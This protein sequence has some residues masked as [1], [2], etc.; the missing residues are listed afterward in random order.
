MDLTERI[1]A[2]ERLRASEAQLRELAETLEQRVE[3]R[4]RER[5]LVWQTSPD[6]L[7][8]AR[9]DG[10]FVTLNPAWE[11]TLGWDE[12]TIKAQRF[13][14][15]VHPDDLA[16]S[17][18][19]MHALTCET[20]VTAFENRYRHRD[21]SYRWFSWNAVPRDGL[22][23]ATV[24]DVTPVKE[25]AAAL[26]EAQERLHQSQKME[27][28]GQL[29][30]GLA[31]DFNN[32]L[33]G[34]IGSLDLLH[35]RIDQ[36][37]VDGLGR[38][39][40]AALASANRA[41]ALTHRLLAFSRRQTLD[42]KPTR[43]NSLIHEMEELIRRTVGPQIELHTEA[44]RDL[45]TILCDPNQLENALLNLCINARDAMPDGG[46][47]LIE[48]ANVHLGEGDLPAGPYVAIAV[49]D[50]GTGMSAEV[51]AR[52]FDPFFTTKPLGMGTGLGLSMIYGF[53][54][55]SGGLANIQSV[56]GAGTRVCLYLPRHLGD[57][58]EETVPD[59]FTEAP[60]ADAGQTVL[61]VDDEPAIRMLIGEVL[62]ELG[63][64]TLEAADGAAGLGALQSDQRIDLLI[65]DVGLP[66]GM[67]GRQMADAARQ[68]RPA[69]KV[70]F[71]TGYAESA[72]IGQGDLEPG[73]HVL[74]KPFS[75]DM[76]ATRVRAILLDA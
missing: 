59:A 38:Y 72:V 42:P 74:T 19:A 16:V 36:G 26:R 49:S 35:T 4:T 14:A 5:D 23:Y 73:M 57:S 44:A 29:T 69:L 37:R 27:A 13:S 76:L 60:R 46:Q 10:H 32:L 52:A 70:L 30:G 21:G 41:A 15:L 66:G 71:I 67:N 39:V 1:V 11:R 62:E 47:L 51:A 3:A 63:Y 56:P 33:T 22:I 64:A 58:E 12:A 9:P 48:T 2:E 6:M 40:D 54:K 28:V 53:A 25:Q 18:Q 34:I 55:Q 75:L 20:T 50:T 43:A 65:S 31:H 7:C 24:R 68:L 17:E 61:V 45:W 8:T